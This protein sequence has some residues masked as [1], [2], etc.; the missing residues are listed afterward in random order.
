MDRYKRDRLGESVMRS[1]LL[2]PINFLQDSLKLPLVTE[3]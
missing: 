1:T 2:Q 3:G